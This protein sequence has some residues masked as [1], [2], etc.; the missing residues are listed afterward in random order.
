MDSDTGFKLP[1]YPV[2]G[3]R[4]SGSGDPDTKTPQTYAGRGLQP[5]FKNV[6]PYILLIPIREP[7]REPD[8]LVPN[9]AAARHRPTGLSVGTRLTGA[10]AAPGLRP[11]R[12]FLL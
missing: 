6:W 5:D 9:R 12:G 8:S 7:D 11:P 3:T 10:V 4:I 1:V 2:V